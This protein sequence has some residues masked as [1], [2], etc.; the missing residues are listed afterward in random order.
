MITQKLTMEKTMKMPTSPIGEL[1]DRVSAGDPEA[2]RRF[3]KEY[4]TLLAFLIRRSQ[5]SLAATGN[6]AAS[7]STCN[8]P[9]TTA[10]DSH[11][12]SEIARLAQRICRRAIGGLQAG[13]RET[14]HDT[15]G[16]RGGWPTAKF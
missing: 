15:V 16:G 13:R 3:E 11:G 10:D 1:C 9:P 7:A 8:R 2:E 14:R 6:T 5:A 12:Q 4:T